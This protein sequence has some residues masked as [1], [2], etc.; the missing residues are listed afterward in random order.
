MTRTDA[1]A[2]HKVR[3]GDSFWHRIGDVGYLDAKDRFWFCGRKAHRVEN[4]Q[5]VMFTIPCEAILNQH[6][7][8][9]RSALVGIGERQQQMPV[10]VVETWP[11]HRPQTPKEEA[12]LLAELWDLAKSHPLT[13]SVRDILLHPSLPVDIR[14]NAK[15][16]REQLA[17]WAEAKLS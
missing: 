9:Y 6:A 16:F 4:L 10:M 17:V 12:Q 3:D 14:H 1:N 2:S 8:V 13:E 5:G 15:I 11:E 7:Q